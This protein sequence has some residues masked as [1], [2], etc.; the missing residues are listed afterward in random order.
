MDRY[1]AASKRQSAGI[2]ALLRD[3]PLMRGHAKTLQGNEGSTDKS[4]KDKRFLCVRH[5][6]QTDE[7]N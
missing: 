3:T 4:I 5:K 1:V 6:L 2:K 7:T